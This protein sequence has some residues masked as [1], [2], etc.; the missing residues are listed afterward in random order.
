[1]SVW[2]SSI[3]VF[4]S[5]YVAYDHINDEPVC[6]LGRYPEGEEDSSVR[7]PITFGAAFAL[8]LET[9]TTV[10][11]GLPNGINSYFEK[12]GVLQVIIY[13]QMAYSMVFNAFLLAFLYARLGRAETRSNQVI[14]SSKALVSIIDGQVRFQVRLFDA[15]SK[16][17]VVEAHVRLYC[18]MNH[19]PVP[20]PLRLLQPN[21]E[22]G[23]MLFLS[24]PTVISHHIDVYSILHPSAEAPLAPSGLILRQVDGVTSNRDDV[25]C[26]VCGESFGTLERWKNHVQY[27]QI[28][29]TKDN[30]PLDN[31][32]R[33]L[34]LARIKEH[35]NSTPITDLDTLKDY[36]RENVSEIICVV[37]GIDPLQSGTFQALQSYRF[38]D[39]VWDENSQFAPCLTITEGKKYRKTGER[40]F[41][42]D[43]NRY[44]DIVLDRQA[45]A[46]QKREEKEEAAMR[47]A[48]VDGGPP[49][50]VHGGEVL[51]DGDL[52]AAPSSD[53]PPEPAPV[54]GEDA[55]NLDYAPGVP[56]GDGEEDVS[57]EINVAVQR[58]RHRRVKTS[59][60]RPGDALFVPTEE[61]KQNGVVPN[62]TEV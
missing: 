45:V 47:A 58:S 25:I 29:E 49:S 52:S 44:H 3:I 2:T 23:G 33:S 53:H 20:R 6:G 40:I 38:E 37:E 41:Q 15:D 61:E 18:V 54:L 9:C 11:Y 14:H 42:V 22:L 10:G 50:S 19:R 31:T 48:S 4:A 5:I 55:P 36:F 34:D 24:F 51:S 26:P 7:D 60:R 28:V 32:H 62:A 35:M 12:C 57:T 30:F 21:D 16:H 17:P 13:F 43:L 59:S 56:F 27:Q 1:M 39:I 46:A 8:S